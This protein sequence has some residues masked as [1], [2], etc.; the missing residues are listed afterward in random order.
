MLVI[1]LEDGENAIVFVQ[2]QHLADYLASYCCEM[3][4]PATSIHEDREKTDQE[5]ALN[6]FKTNKIKVLISTSVLAKGLG[7][8]QN[9]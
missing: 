9:L 1:I 5:E 2:G 7:I 8:Y 6:N 3:D 4:I